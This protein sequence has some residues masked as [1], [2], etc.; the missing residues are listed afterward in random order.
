MDTDRAGLGTP[1]CMS[2]GSRAGVRIPERR[3]WPLKG[4]TLQENLR[5]VLYT[6]FYA[7]LALGAYRREGV[8]IEF[9]SASEP[10]RAVPKS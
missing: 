8:T 9:V 6:S 4:V 10:A 1:K 5:G 2:P 7:A 3:I